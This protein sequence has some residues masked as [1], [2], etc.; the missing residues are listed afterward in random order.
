MGMLLG[1]MARANPQWRSFGELAAAGHQALVAFSGAHAYISPNWYGAGPAVP[2][3][4]YQA[5]HAYGIPRIIHDRASARQLVGALVARHESG[6]EAPWSADSQEADY[7][8]KM[9]RGIVAFE[10][11][12]VRLEIK[13]KLSQ[14]RSAEDRAGVIVGLERSASAG[15]HELAK[16]M[17]QLD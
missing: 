3:W 6:F 10:V 8:D 16:L 9:V 13:A 4:N 14:N 2:T 7:L 12:V 5:V 11:P 1:H 15:D 17:R